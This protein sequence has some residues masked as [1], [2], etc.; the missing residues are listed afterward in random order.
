M[1][2]DKSTC[3]PLLRMHPLLEKPC[4]T[5]SRRKALAKPV[6]NRGGVLLLP[7]RLPLGSLLQQ[8]SNGKQAWATPQKM[9]KPHRRLKQTVWK[10]C[11][12]LKQRSS[13]RGSTKSVGP[14]PSCSQRLQTAWCPFRFSNCHIQESRGQGHQ[15]RRRAPR[16]RGSPE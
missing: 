10:S 1:Q 4:Q 14:A 6:G 13:L 7:H 2:L 16:C 5:H 9:T 3:V 15:M 11:L 8:W 12:L